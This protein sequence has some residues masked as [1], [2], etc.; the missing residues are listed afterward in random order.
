MRNYQ[1]LVDRLK[2]EERLKKKKIKEDFS[3]TISR[4][5]NRCAQTHAFHVYKT[6]GKKSVFI[7]LLIEAINR[8]N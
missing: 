1:T 8:N 7:S 4:D 6:Q 2:M 3:R 5:Y